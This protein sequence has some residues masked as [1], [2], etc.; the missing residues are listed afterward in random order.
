MGELGSEVR[1]ITD[2]LDSI[3]NTTAAVGKGFAIGSAA[4]TSLA[5]FAAYKTAVTYDDFTLDLGEPS[6][7]M[8]LLIGGA[9][10]F[11]V[12]A[13]TM[14]SVGKAAGE[15]VVEIRRQFRERL[16]VF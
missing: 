8:G 16:T 12:A 6:V 7:V 5:L 2:A 1:E 10:P 15:M 9:L 13:M 3:G 14:T 4:L 11:V